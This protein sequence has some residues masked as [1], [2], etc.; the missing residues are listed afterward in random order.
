MIKI[1]SKRN[2]YTYNVYHLA[3]SFFP[4]EEIIQKVDEK[5]EPLAVLEMPGEAAGRK[6]PGAVTRRKRRGSRQ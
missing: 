2:K 6:A 5:Q 3:K 4:D 1:S